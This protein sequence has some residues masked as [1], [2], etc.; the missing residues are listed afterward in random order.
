M[1]A[2]EPRTLPSAAAVEKHAFRGCGN[3]SQSGERSVRPTRC[4]EFLDSIDRAEA[5]GATA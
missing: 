5:G 4:S 2:I 3:H 1:G